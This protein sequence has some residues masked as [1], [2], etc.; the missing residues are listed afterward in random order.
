MYREVQVK[1]ILLQNLFLHLFVMWVAF[2]QLFFIDLFNER[3]SEDSGIYFNTDKM[4]SF[5]WKTLFCIFIETS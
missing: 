1:K 5:E 2:K 4:L 3:T